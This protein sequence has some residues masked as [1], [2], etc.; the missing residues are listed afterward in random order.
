MLPILDDSH[1]WASHT[2]IDDLGNL[3][4]EVLL[5]LKASLPN[6]PAAIHEE[7]NVNFTICKEKYGLV[8]IQ[9][10]QGVGQWKG[11]SSEV[12]KF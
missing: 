2:H 6:A 10:T 8:F 11:S 5:D 3:G 9:Q 4:Q 7:G 1:H 12:Y